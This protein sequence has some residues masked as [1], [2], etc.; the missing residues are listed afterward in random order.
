MLHG[1]VLKTKDLGEAASLLGDAAIPYSSELLAGSPAFSTEIFVTP[2]QRV[3]LSRVVT[4]GR[5][6]VK[7]RLPADSYALVLDLGH[8][9]GTHRVEGESMSVDSGHT[10]LQSPLQAV[11]VA[12]TDQYDILF[13]KL[14]RQVVVD[15]LEKMLDRNTRADLVFAHDFPMH[16]MAGKQLRE[17]CG[18]I[19]RT[20]YSTDKQ[21]IEGSLPLRNLEDGLIRLLLE[22][23]P[24]NYMRSLNRRRDAGAWHVRAAE[25]Y[26]RAN[27]HLPLSL[28]DICH[29]AG[30]N[31]RTLQHGFR[32]KRGCSPMDFLRATRM[33]EVRSGL[34]NPEE[35]ASVTS[36]A[37]HWGF[38]HF[39]R[40]AREYRTR[41]GEKPS[42][43][44]RRARG[45]RK[46][47]ASE[48]SGS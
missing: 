23:Q 44:L 28:G 26:I 22:A 6:R 24:H 41:Y 30:V 32:R 25:E 45:A 13:L 18:S 20:L 34:L 1:L 14:A 35:D 8:G 11:E 47:P 38:L 7:S 43:T 27:A 15:E 12:T 5:L 40:F 2:G 3:C 4:T 10:F 48:Q 9:A 39:G 33:Q 46:K 36:E 37:A 42:E 29:A 17:L 19:R 31:V 16:T 21:N